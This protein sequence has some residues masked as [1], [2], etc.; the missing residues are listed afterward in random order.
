MEQTTFLRVE[1]GYRVADLPEAERPVHRLR[2]VGPRA[3]S[4]AELLACILQSGEALDQANA[5]LV[6]MGGLAGL[7][8]AD[9]VMFESIRGIGPAQAARLYAA[10]ELGRRLTLESPLDVP[11]ITAPWVVADFL[12]SLISM[13]EQENFVVLY[14][15]TRN[16]VMTHEVLYRGT[17]NT[18]A[19]RAAEVFRGAIRRNSATIIVAHNHPSGNPEPSPADIEMTRRLVEAGRLVEV[20]VLDHLV[21]GHGRYVSLRDRGLGFD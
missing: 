8:H 7:A 12:L 11:Q 21:I 20:E 5:L 9:A 15:N 17:L 13:E 18:S 10:V 16:Q 1:S 3:V 6:E 2:E 19:V 4:N 14:L